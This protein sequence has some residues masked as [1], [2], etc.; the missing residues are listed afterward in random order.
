MWHLQQVYG[1]HTPVHSG[2]EC[3]VFCAVCQA[4]GLVLPIGLPPHGLLDH[5]TNVHVQ[6]CSHRFCRPCLETSI[7]GQLREGALSSEVACATCSAP[8]SIRDVQVS[9]PRQREARQASLVLCRCAHVLD[10]SSVRLART[11]HAVPLVGRRWR[12]TAP[13]VLPSGCTRS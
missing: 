3:G 11:S 7:L 12:C 6:E 9:I 10:G 8:M 2:C 13:L 1:H 4:A 5:T